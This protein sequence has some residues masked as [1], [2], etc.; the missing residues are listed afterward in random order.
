MTPPPRLPADVL[1]EVLAHLR[2]PERQAG[3]GAVPRALP[4]EA[5][6][7]KS[8]VPLL[9]QQQYRT[10]C[11]ASFRQ[12]S[13]LARSVAQR[14]ELGA[15]VRTLRLQR[16]A[17]WAL[18]DDDEDDDDDDDDDDY[19]SDDD[20]GPEAPM[21]GEFLDCAAMWPL[22]QNLVCLRL[23][24]VEEGLDSFL[25][26]VERGLV[27]PSLSKLS[28]GSTF[29]RGLNLWDPARWSQILAAAP[30]LTEVEVEYLAPDGL[31]DTITLPATGPPARPFASA[32]RSLTLK[33]YDPSQPE[34][35]AHL[36]NAFAGL[37]ALRLVGIVALDVVP[38]LRLP[39]LRSLG[40]EPA[41]EVG[42]VV[43]ALDLRHLPAL[44][45][46]TL[47]C[48]NVTRRYFTP[49]LSLVLPSAVTRLACTASSQVPFATLLDLIAPRPTKHLPL[50]HVHLD[51]CGV[52][53]YVTQQSRQV[54]GRPGGRGYD[55]RFEEWR[56]WHEGRSPGQLRQLVQ[57]AQ[58]QG[59]SLT[60]DCLA[61]HAY[62]EAVARQA[63][64]S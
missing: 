12:F 27:L 24:N 10:I 64:R 48:V 59:T 62:E 3:S 42:G 13:L 1:L 16:Q 21:A 17:P 32:V 43:S 8:L 63:G 26:A 29:A 37:A 5:F 49:E 30:S 20:D 51:I 15:F 25:S 4:T 54:D 22:L 53:E 47:G 7:T 34:P 57:V 6:F 58:E 61:L 14:P 56:G 36:A 45:E 18:E 9:H 2:L 41:R 52:E 50:K 35:V 33:A 38:G 44:E 31:A 39:A 55:G 19:D 23:F 46:V 60:G 40:Y 28:L 11:V